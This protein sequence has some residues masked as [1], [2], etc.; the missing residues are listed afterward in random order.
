MRTPDYGNGDWNIKYARNRDLP[1]VREIG[2]RNDTVHIALSEPADSIVFTGQDH[3]LLYCSDNTDKAEYVFSN[4]DS[5]ARITVYF[6]DGE[7]IYSNPF[8]RYDKSRSDSPFRPARHSVN[9]ILTLLYNLS[10]AVIFI[11]LVL[12]V[13]TIIKK[14]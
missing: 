11:G 7:V 4:N 12:A 3:R 5:Y 10:L 6:A 1:Y 2:L 13:R 9:V 14:R 8:A